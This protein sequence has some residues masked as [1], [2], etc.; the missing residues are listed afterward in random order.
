MR[1]SPWRSSEK[2]GRGGAAAAT[3]IFRGDSKTGRF[4]R[5]PGYVA[6]SQ[7]CILTV[8][9]KRRR[10]SLAQTQPPRP[11]PTTSTRYGSSA[12]RESSA[13]VPTSSAARCK[14][15]AYSRARAPARGFTSSASA[16]LQPTSTTAAAAHGRAARCHARRNMVAIARGGCLG[17]LARLC[18]S[19][20]R[21]RSR[22]CEA[23]GLLR[24]AKQSKGASQRHRSVERRPRRARQIFASRPHTFAASSEEG[25][26]VRR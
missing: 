8:S 15:S 11:A 14:S 23:R 9:P 13:S 10:S 6:R 19:R 24:L 4:R 1:S 20:R 18:C 17:T 7:T 16:R 21:S 12:R 5:G 3:W 25:C 22:R 26:S 2:A